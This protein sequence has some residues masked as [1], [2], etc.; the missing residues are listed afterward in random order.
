V[1]EQRTHANTKLI[2]ATAGVKIA[3]F[4]VST[5]RVNPRVNPHG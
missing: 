3:A 4:A 1:N 5:P 2:T